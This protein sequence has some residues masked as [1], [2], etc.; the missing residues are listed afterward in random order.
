MQFLALLMCLL[1][2]NIGALQVTKLFHS[3]TLNRVILRSSNSDG[4]YPTQ[5]PIIP[6][7][8]FAREDIPMPTPK[9][10]VKQPVQERSKIKSDKQPVIQNASGWI[11]DPNRPT[12]YGRPDLDDDEDEMQ[13]KMIEDNWLPP[14]D[15]TPIQKWFRDT[16]IGSPYDSRKKK[17][18]RYVITNITIISFAI[19]FIF[20][21]IWYAFPGKF[22]SVRGDTDFT[23]RY[24]SDFVPPQGL[25]SDEWSKPSQVNPQDTG[26]FFDEGREGLP[27]I[28]QTRFP[29]ERNDK[30]LQF[31][32][33]PRID[34]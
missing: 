10:E 4:N 25:L 1:Y 2:Q 8:G 13:Q 17:Q 16:Y 6:F 27:E 21:A 12:G 3:I 30:P 26:S 19:G 34:L 29:L 18:A 14:A 9:V 24:S 23:A 11:E 28:E 22:I 5:P 20:T 31:A 15:E 32:P 7:D 33:P